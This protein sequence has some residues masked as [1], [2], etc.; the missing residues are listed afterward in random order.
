MVRL[1]LFD[2][3]MFAADGADSILPFID[4]SF[5]V[6]VKSADVEMMFVVIR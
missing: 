6:V 1:H 4:L 5:H 3:E 2:F